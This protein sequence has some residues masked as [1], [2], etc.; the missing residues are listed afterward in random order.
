MLGLGGLIERMA[1]G[2]QVDVLSAM[3]LVGEV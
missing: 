2:Q 1:A 3:A